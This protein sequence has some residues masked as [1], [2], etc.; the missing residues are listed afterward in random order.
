M[1]S[2]TNIKQVV[3][4]QARQAGILFHLESTRMA[5]EFPIFQRLFPSVLTV[6][7]YNKNYAM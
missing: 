4:S 7:L 5:V 6:G 2:L 1:V 3:C